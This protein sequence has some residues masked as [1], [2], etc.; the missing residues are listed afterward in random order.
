MAKEIKLPTY[1]EAIKEFAKSIMPR[2]RTYEQMERRG[3]LPNGYADKLIAET[4]ESHIYA[5]SNVV[6]KHKMAEYKR[7]YKHED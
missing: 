6:V 7:R 4:I 2:Y 3:E 5:I 1:D